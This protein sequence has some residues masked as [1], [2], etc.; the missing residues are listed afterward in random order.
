LYKRKKRDRKSCNEKASLAALVSKFKS[1]NEEYLKI[2][3]TTEEK[4]K[5][6][7]TNGNLILKFATLSV[8]ESLGT[9]PE[10]YNF[11]S[12]STSA[13]TTSTTYG[14]N[15]L[16]LV[17][18][19]RQQHQQSFNDNYTALILEESE[20]LYNNLTTELTNSVMAAAAYMGASSLPSLGNNTNNQKLTYKNNAYQTE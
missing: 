10:L 3:Q 5:D 12:Y 8:I 4:V 6:A 17:S 19:G 9:N 1:N 15:Y 20:K 7:L 18:S 13:E 2:K 16:S 14:S 11:I